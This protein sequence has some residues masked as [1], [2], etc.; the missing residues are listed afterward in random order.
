MRG[1]IEHGRMRR[2][3]SCVQQSSLRIGSTSLFCTRIGA[4]VHVCVCVISCVDGYHCP[5]HSER[6]ACVVCP[7]Y[8]ARH[9]LRNFIP[10]EFIPS[11]CDLVVWGHEH[12][13]R[14]V[15]EYRQF[16]VDDSKGFYITQPG[17]S[18]ATS[19]VDG[20]AKLK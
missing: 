15:E 20:E 11:W 1:C 17:S 4:C 5:A 7:S 6:V 14:V 16:G 18:V 12:E 19:L 3:N 9:G 10:E 13:C 2:S 8:R